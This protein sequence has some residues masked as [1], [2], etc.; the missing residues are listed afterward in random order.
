MKTET[1]FQEGKEAKECLILRT[2]HVDFLGVMTLGGWMD[3]LS[4]LLVRVQN[5]VCSG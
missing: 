4:Q 1:V 2:V 3:T 5:M